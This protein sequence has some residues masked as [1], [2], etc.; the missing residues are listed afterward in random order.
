MIFD[1][2]LFIHPAY[3]HAHA[4]DA[5]SCHT[6]PDHDGTATKLES[7]FYK[8]ATEASAFDSTVLPAIRSNEDDLI[9]SDH[10]RISSLQEH[11]GDTAL[12]SASVGWFWS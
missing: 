8:L 12:Y 11:E 5:F 4:T 3:H 9:L 6:A 2:L 1:V 7:R 10:V